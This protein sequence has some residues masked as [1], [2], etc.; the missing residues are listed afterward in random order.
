MTVNTKCSTGPISRLG[1]ALIDDSGSR[2]I[3]RTTDWIA[4]RAASGASDLY[5]FGYGTDYRRALHD[6]SVVA[7]SVP[8]VP[9]FTLGVWWSRYW[10][11]TA[12]DLLD[13]ADGYGTRSLPIDIVV[14]DMAWHFHNETGAVDWGGYTWSSELFPEPVRG[15]A[16]GPALN[17]VYG[18]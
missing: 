1:W 16:T 15:K 4:D 7:G 17:N 2:V 18:I 10:P 3:S 6:Y 9:R 11:Y 13:I 12:E 14:S 5:L 8:Q